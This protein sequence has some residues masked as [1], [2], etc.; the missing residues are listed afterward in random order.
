MDSSIRQLTVFLKRILRAI[1]A[2][3]ET[4]KAT[5]EYGGATKDAVGTALCKPAGPVRTETDLAP[6]AMQRYQS[7]EDSTY[8]LQRK[9]YCVRVI[10]LIILGFYTL[11]TWWLV[12]VSRD[13]LEATK[14]SFGKTLCQMQAQTDAQVRAA[15]AAV[16]AN[17]LTRQLF[18]ETQGPV[19]EM[20]IDFNNL[21]QPNSMIGTT[22]AN[23]RHPSPWIGANVN[24]V[25]KLPAR[26]AHAI[27]DFLRLD[28]HKKIIQSIQ[29]QSTDDAILVGRGFWAMFPVMPVRSGP[30][31]YQPETFKVK[32]IIAYDDGFGAHREQ[33]FCREL[34]ITQQ[35]AWV[36]CEDAKDWKEHPP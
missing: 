14:Q 8:R 23:P 20:L 19:F 10:T 6:R 35:V 22:L 31:E 13:S 27:F 36:E 25:G 18:S 2:P 1:E 26:N 29:K 24:N 4:S 16:A 7:Q 28:A 3:H 12:K 11:A 32:A 17:A 30:S 34:A 21:M 5:A 15:N 33:H 9:D